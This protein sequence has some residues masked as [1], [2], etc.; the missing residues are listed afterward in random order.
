[1]AGGREMSSAAA[2]IP[3][4]TVRM[5]RVM[6][7]CSRSWRRKL[8]KAL[9]S[10]LSP[11]SNFCALVMACYLYLTAYFLQQAKNKT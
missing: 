11:Q 8:E 5:R 3:R 7:D 6:E 4:A 1:M 10:H 2:G 9:R